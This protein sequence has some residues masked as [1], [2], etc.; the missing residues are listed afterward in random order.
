MADVRKIEVVIYEN[1]R[2][3]HSLN[4]RYFLGQPYQVKIDTPDG[5]DCI[6]EGRVPEPDPGPITLE[7][8]L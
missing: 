6:Y 2:E 5:T 4:V 8:E 7:A 1:G 3:I